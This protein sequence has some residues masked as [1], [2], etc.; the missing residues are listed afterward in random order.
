MKK[1]NQSQEEFERIDRYLDG[2]MSREEQTKFEDSLKTDRLLNQQV[3]ETWLLHQAVEEQSLRNK[4]EDFHA[5]MIPEDAESKS[6]KPITGTVF[7]YYKAFAIAASLVLLMGFGYWLLFGQMS[8]D[9]KLFAQYFKPDPGLLTPMSTTSDYEFYRGMVDYKQGKYDL[10]IQRWNPLLKQKPE[11]DTLNFY[12]GISY[13]AQNKNEEAIEY[14]SK[15]VNNPN[16]IFINESWYYLGMVQLKEGRTEE[17][18]SSFKMSNLE[19][20]R[21]ILKELKHAK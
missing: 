14:L 10:A 12:L 13:L 16:S 1:Q 20:S 7:G 2:L 4:L 9:E 15:A 6:N 11:N 5:E 21:L 18:I 8:T 3:E 17:A 19:G